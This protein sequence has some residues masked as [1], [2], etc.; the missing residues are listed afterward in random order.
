MDIVKVMV[1]ALV[2]PEPSQKLFPR[3]PKL[4]EIVDTDTYLFWVVF[5]FAIK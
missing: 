2:F 3:T 1:C 5:E 4:G